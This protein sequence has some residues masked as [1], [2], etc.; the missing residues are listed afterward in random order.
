MNEIFKLSDHIHFLPVVH[1]CASFSREIRNNILSEKCDCLAVALPP[2]FQTSV[3][4]GI[5]LLPQIT[6]STQQETDGGLN[7][8]PIDP[9]QPLIA[10]LRVAKQEGISRQFIDWSTT[11]YETRHTNFP[12]TFSL[13]KVSYEKLSSTLLLTVKPPKAE[14]QHYWRTCWMA[15]QLSLIHI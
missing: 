6:L 15:Y 2:E 1:G 7:Y 5:D 4:E 14:S 3:E 8:I 13:R 11:N 12:D 9:S 10:G